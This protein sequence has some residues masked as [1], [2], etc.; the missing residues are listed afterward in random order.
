MSTTL[1]IKNCYTIWMCAQ[2]EWNWWIIELQW[3]VGDRNHLFRDKLLPHLARKK[4]K[5]I[6]Y[7][8][9]SDDNKSYFHNLFE[10]NTIGG[11][12]SYFYYRNH[13]SIYVLTKDLKNIYQHKF[14][15]SD[16]LLATGT[17]CT[18][19][20]SDISGTE[21]FEFDNRSYEIDFPECDGTFYLYSN[22]RLKKVVFPNLVTVYIV[23]LVIYLPV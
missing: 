19:F 12:N 10:H 13:L 14:Q 5:Q 21:L 7:S 22:I 2:V 6:N 8:V 17:E 1:Q 23:A 16:A 3:K 11:Q 20:V 15:F 9:H 18:L 4:Q